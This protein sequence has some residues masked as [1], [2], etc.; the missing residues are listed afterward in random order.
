[1]RTSPAIT[2]ND[3]N[4]CTRTIIERLLWK[5]ETALTGL[6]GAARGYAP[7]TVKLRLTY[8]P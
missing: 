4:I 2:N 6:S 1:M 8:T 7:N 5:T 3:P